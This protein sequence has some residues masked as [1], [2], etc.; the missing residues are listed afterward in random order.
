MARL[1]IW[2][3]ILSITVACQSADSTSADH[4]PV[5]KEEPKPFAYGQQ[6]STQPSQEEVPQKIKVNQELKEKSGCDFKNGIHAAAV[7][8]F[9]PK[10][11]HTATY[12]D[13]K[14]HIINCAVVRIDFPNGGWLDEDH[15]PPQPSTIAASPN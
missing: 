9:N 6:P 5:N 11:G 2:L 7:G 10:T 14:V 8:Y 3:T 13:L 4:R 1:L 12:D 15:I